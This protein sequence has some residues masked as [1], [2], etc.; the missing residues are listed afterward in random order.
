MPH[1]TTPSP[2]V[3]LRPRI[4]RNAKDPNE[5][6]ALSEVE[7]IYAFLRGVMKAGWPILTSRS[8]RR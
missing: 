2:F 3:I 8:L 4:L 1:A 7:G 6:P 5:E